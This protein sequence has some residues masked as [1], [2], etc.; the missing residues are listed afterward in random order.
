M[1]HAQMEAA[2]SE[3]LEFIIET[4]ENITD[5]IDIINKEDWIKKSFA[6]SLGSMAVYK[7]LFVTGS[8][9]MEGIMIFAIMKRYLCLYCIFTSI[10]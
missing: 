9:K 3:D 5:G 2:P 7:E 10:T 6:I 1:L 4:M 8:E